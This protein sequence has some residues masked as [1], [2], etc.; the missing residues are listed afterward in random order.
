MKHRKKR[1]HKKERPQLQSRTSPVV[2]G[3]E[4]RLV[5]TSRWHRKRIHLLG[6]GKFKRQSVITTSKVV[7]VVGLL[8]SLG[9]LVP[10]LFWSDKVRVPSQ[11]VD[12]EGGAAV[13]NSGAGEVAENLLDLSESERALLEYRRLVGLNNVQSLL[14]HGSYEE[15]GRVFEMKLAVKAPRLIRKGLRDQELEIVAAHDGGEA[16]VRVGQGDVLSESQQLEDRLYLASL[17]LEGAFLFPVQE[18]DDSGRS[19]ES[20]NRRVLVNGRE[21]WEFRQRH[22]EGEAVFHYIDTEAYL[23]RA[24]KLV[25]PVGGGTYDLMLHVTGYRSSGDF[26][27]PQ[28]YVIKVNDEVRGIAR[29]ERSQ[30]NAGLMHWHFQL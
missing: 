24:R 1:Q 28:G 27:V 10:A 18:D 6:L 9:L 2:A 16:R 19:I 4:E 20:M 29:C 17:Q 11:V 25:L 8:V 5:S 26:M 15:D 13:A 12:G 7:L 21:C 22:G 3:S 14:L 30:V 23:E